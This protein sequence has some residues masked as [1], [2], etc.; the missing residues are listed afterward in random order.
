MLRIDGRV[1][2]PGQ[3]KQRALL[4]LLALSPGV[5]VALPEII[6]ALWDHAPSA[7][8]RNQIQVYVSRLRQQISAIPID[9]HPAGY[10]LD[11]PAECVDLIRFEHAVIRAGHLIRDGDLGA[12]D[13][14]LCE[15]LRQWTGRPLSG[16][17][18]VYFERLADQLQERRLSALEQHVHVRLGLVERSGGDF[19]ELTHN[20]RPAVTANP[21]HEGLRHGLMLALYHDGRPAEAL[22]VYR[23]GRQ[24]IVDELGIEPG[25]RLRSLELRILRGDR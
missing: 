12:A 5:P 25:P 14:V 21:L 9:T 18:G 22:A 2:H 4:A 17:P 16:V 23:E 19:V 24:R 15:A 8:A 20:L 7:G 13:Q 1:V 11:L 3:P 6:D 10:V